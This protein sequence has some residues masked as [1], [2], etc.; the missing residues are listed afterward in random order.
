MHSLVLGHRELKLAPYISRHP[1]G[2][3]L[4]QKRVK[5]VVLRSIYGYGYL[6]RDFE[7][8]PIE[9]LSMQQFLA[10]QKN[11]EAFNQFF[12][13]NQNFVFTVDVNY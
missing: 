8:Q 2:E 6:G 5:F 7:Y 9:I 13:F 4:E 11:F 10:W 12:T 3:N 1:V